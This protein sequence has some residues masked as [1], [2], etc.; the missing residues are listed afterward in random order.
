MKHMHQ[1]GIPNEICTDNSSQFQ[2]VF[3]EMLE[4][5]SILDFKIQPYS[6][7][8]NSL[9]ERANKEVLRH[10]RNFIFDSKVI[11]EWPSYLSQV[12]QIM[13]SHVSKSTGVS[14]VE[15]VFAGQ[16]DLN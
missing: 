3:K 8:E 15:M 6:H 10:L 11:A 14:P 7:Q 9:V 5:L 1:F 4:Y 13:N 12:E 16:V 2:S